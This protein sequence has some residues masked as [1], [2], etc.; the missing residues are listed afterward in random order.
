MPLNS[1]QIEKFST[2]LADITWLKAWAQGFDTKM[3]RLAT[4]IKDD[5]EADRDAMSEALRRHTASCPV[6]HL[7]KKV[8][9]LIVRTAA[10][11]AGMSIL[12]SIVIA[13]MAAIFRAAAQ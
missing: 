9:T 7:Q 1:D 13:G 8:D 4:E 11:A 3:E 10:L 5:R 2:A 12:V 6:N